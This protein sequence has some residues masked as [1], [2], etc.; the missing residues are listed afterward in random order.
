MNEPCE[1][2]W[3]PGECGGCAWRRIYELLEEHL[4]RQE[5]GLEAVRFVDA[6]RANFRSPS[7]EWERRQRVRR[8]ARRRLR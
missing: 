2:G 1:H 7:D 8:G 3:P 5:V 4:A 6:N